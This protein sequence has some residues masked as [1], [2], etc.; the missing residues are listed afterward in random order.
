MKFE[1]RAIL[2][3]LTFIMGIFTFQQS[4]AES[5]KEKKFKFQNYKNTEMAMQDILESHPIGSDVN[6]LIGNLK[7]SGAKED[8][9]ILRREIKKSD[10]WKGY[11]NK[12]IRISQSEYKS[13]EV[14]N[15]ATRAY[16]Y[17]KSTGIIFNTKLWK[18][19][20]WSD[21]DN[22]ITDLTVIRDYTGL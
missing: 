21:K 15:L 8:K 9:T 19:S 11:F 5:I 13:V 10:E 3:A 2:I 18:I 1:I 12:T 16:F 17:Q 7:K 20:F 22:K 6:L 4:V 14:S